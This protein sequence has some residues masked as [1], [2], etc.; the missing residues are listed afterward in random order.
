LKG[1]IKMVD[2]LGRWIPESD[3]KSYPKYKWCDM[4]YIANYIAEQKYQPKTTVENLASMIILHFE[5]E[6]ENENSDFLPAY[7]KNLMININKVKEFVEASGGL[8]EFDYSV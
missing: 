3:Y 8:K 5:G 6:I 1:D 7:N 2:S 4:D